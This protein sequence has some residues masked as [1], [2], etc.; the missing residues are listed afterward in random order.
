MRH[1]FLSYSD[2][3]TA[4]MGHIII[5]LARPSNK[6]A[7]PLA[8]FHIYERGCHPLPVVAKS[9]KLYWPVPALAVQER[10]TANIMTMLSSLGM[11]SP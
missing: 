4:C 9:G 5:A 11:T 10:Q 6:H 8:N 7:N 3:D 2:D 1:V